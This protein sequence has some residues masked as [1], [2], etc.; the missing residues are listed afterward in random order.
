MLV[1]GALIAADVAAGGPTGEGIAPAMAMRA[2]RE[3]AEQ[4]GETAAGQLGRSV[5]GSEPPASAPV[6]RRTPNAE[7]A[8]RQ[9][10]TPPG[11]PRNAAGTAGNRQY[12]GHAFDQMQNRG[13]TPSVVDDAIVSGTRTP[14]GDGVS[15]YTSSANNVTVIVD[16]ATGRIITAY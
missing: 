4:A 11:A 5:R 8:N 1:E 3:G 15:A 16:D 14:A 13:L 7:G 6:G 9:L 10:Q 12:S 2:A